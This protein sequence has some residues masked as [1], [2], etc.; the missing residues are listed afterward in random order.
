[1]D[2]KQINDILNAGIG[3]VKTSKEV[4]D[5]LASDLNSKKTELQ[6]AFDKYKEQGEKDWSE[7]AAKVKVGV[8]WGIVKFEEIRDKVVEYLD[9]AQKKT[10]KDSEGEKK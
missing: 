4:W 6:S 3:A 10:N 2:S 1:M 8:A 5:K 9:N 7:N